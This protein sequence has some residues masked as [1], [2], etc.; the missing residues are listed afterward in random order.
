MLKTMRRAGFVILL[1]LAA[2][3]AS[4]QQQYMVPMLDGTELMTVV[5]LPSSGEPPWPAVL[6][7]TPYPRSGG[8]KQW[9]R[10]GI[11]YVEQSVR[12]RFGSEGEYRPFADDGWAGH[13]DGA[14]T[15][16]W[17]RSRPWCDSRVGTMGGSATAIT[18]ILLAGASPSVTCQVMQ[19][20]GSDFAHDFVYQGGVFRKALGEGWLRGGVRMPGY[21]AVWQGQLPTSP[22]W[23]DYDA[24]A[25]APWITAPGLHVGGWWDIFAANTVEH[26]VQRQNHGGKGARGNQKLVMRPTAHG[27]WRDQSLQF[28]PN[29]DAFKVTPYRIRWY[30]HWLTGEA[31]GIMDE[32][33]VTY[34]TV[35]DDRAFDGPG[36]EWRT[37]DQWPPFPGEPTPYYLAPEKALA[38]NA[39]AQSELSF[40]FD[41]ENPVPTVGGANLVLPYGPHDQRP[42]SGRPDVLRFETPA[43]AAPMEVTGNVRVRLFVS[44]DAP[45]TDF[46][47]KLVDVYP[48]EDGREILIMDSIQ[49]VKYRDE[50]SAAVPPLQPGQVVPIEIKLGPTSWVFNTGHRVGLHIS[51][52]NF[53]RFEINPNTGDD[54][55]GP[56]VTPRKAT[57]TV[58]LGPEHP[59]AI[60]L[61]CRK[62]R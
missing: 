36:W 32:P 46:T 62:D 58:H 42:V 23:H 17:V 27:G 39:P 57:N 1:L 13:R 37:A 22:Y 55:P 9:T 5:Y 50:G 15:V 30:R 59:S 49:R 21:V 60:L 25:R 10:Q 3:T 52:S 28:P 54:F 51:S 14:V 29:Y 56:D 11:A 12:G 31:N 45:D 33:A 47:A 6:Q 24:D 19:D 16:E 2:V 40:T 61:P 35:G 48:P 41:P 20:G 18:S 43:F 44:S 4:A 38:V 53:P 26:F 34:Y 7:R 8:G